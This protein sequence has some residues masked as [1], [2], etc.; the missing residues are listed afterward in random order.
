MSYPTIGMLPSGL[1]PRNRAV[2]LREEGTFDVDN[3]SISILPMDFKPR[4]TFAG[5]YKYNTGVKHCVERTSAWFPPLFFQ[6][7]NP[8]WVTTANSS[9]LDAQLDA[10]V[11]DVD[12]DEQIANFPYPKIMADSVDIAET[13][14]RDHAAHWGAYGSHKNT[15]NDAARDYVY[16]RVLP[17]ACLLNTS[18]AADE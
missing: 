10:L 15:I 1:R 14:K 4:Q 2:N 17:T 13:A 7:T 18:D 5:S 11:R 16:N 8:N 3:P 12:A 9:H 6:L